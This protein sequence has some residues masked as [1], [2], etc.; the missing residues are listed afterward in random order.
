LSLRVICFGYEEG[1]VEQGVARF[2]RAH[3]AGFLQLF[4]GRPGFVQGGL[5]RGHQFFARAPSGILGDQAERTVQM[6]GARREV[7][8]KQGLDF[9]G[10]EAGIGGVRGGC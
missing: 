2:F 6:D 3:K 4:E 8:V 9:C 1:G 5:A 10:T 7:G